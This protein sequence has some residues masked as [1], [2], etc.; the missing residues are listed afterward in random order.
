MS[1]TKAILDVDASTGTLNFAPTDKSDFVCVDTKVNGETREA[2]Y[3]RAV[4]ADDVDHP[5]YMRQ[6]YYP[7]GAGEEATASHSAKITTWISLTDSVSGE[8]IYKPFTITLATNGPGK[9]GG[10]DAPEFPAIV[11]NLVSWWL[12][13]VAAAPSQ[14]AIDQLKRGIVN[15][16]ATLGD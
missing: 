12:P 14:L 8:V 11:H 5:S 1:I 10:I 2:I 4:D 15:Q 13:T 7:K 16:L 3:Q 6:G 9:T